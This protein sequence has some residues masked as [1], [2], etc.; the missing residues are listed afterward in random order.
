[1][2]INI[3]RKVAVA[4]IAI[5]TLFVTSCEFLVST[6][7]NITTSETIVSHEK[8]NIFVNVKCKG[9]WSLYLVTLDGNDVDWARLE[10]G[11]IRTRLPVT[12]TVSRPGRTP[13]T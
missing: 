11:V 5:C 3:I 6:D 9:N 12:A 4:V 8:G 7:M 10:E 2:K 1:M 13:T